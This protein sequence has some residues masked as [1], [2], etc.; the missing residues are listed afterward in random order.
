MI[1]SGFDRRPLS[2]RLAA[3]RRRLRLVVTVRGVSWFLSVMLL[4]IACAGILDWRLHLPG[5]VRAAALTG[6]LAGAGVIALRCLILPL[7]A[8]ADDFALALR[9]EERYPYLNDCLASTVQFLER[10]ARREPVD[11][12]QGSQS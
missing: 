1:Q 9:I 2:R 4:A 12:T 11:E 7:A 8:R 10:A 5:L 6:T 3:L